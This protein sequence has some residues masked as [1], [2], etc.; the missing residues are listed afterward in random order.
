MT[1][2]AVKPEMAGFPAPHH[3]IQDTE[4]VST[5]TEEIPDTQEANQDATGFLC[6]FCGQSFTS[7]SA[8]KVRH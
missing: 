1:D 2:F 6:G 7:R 4:T 3:L 5:I 8:F